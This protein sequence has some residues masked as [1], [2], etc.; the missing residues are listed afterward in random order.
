MVL[1]NRMD[2]LKVEPGSSNETCVTSILDG[3][4]ET[5]IE[6]EVVS[7]MT[8]EEDREPRAIPVIKIEPTVSV[9]PVVS[10]SHISYM[11]SVNKIMILPVYCKIWQ[12]CRLHV[13]VG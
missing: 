2:L 4:E 11:W 7:S 10:V 3:K 13:K 6:A 1:Q 12:Q 8:E 9:V 5:G